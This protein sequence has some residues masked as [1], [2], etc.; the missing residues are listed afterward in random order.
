MGKAEV[1]SLLRD[2]EYVSGEE[3]S[4]ALGVTRAAHGKQVKLARLR[5]LQ[6]C[7]LHAE[8]A[9]RR[10]PVPCRVFQ[11]IQRHQQRY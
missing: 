7:G 11:G 2:G 10:L 9:Q 8:L 3:I 6:P 4:R 5:L 1:L